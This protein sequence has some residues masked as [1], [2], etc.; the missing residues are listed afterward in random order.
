MVELRETLQITCLL[1][2]EP[3]ALPAGLRHGLTLEEQI[4]RRFGAVALL[5]IGQSGRANAVVEN[6]EPTLRYRNDMVRPIDRDVAIR[7][8]VED[9]ELVADTD[10]GSAVQDEQTSFLRV[11]EIARSCHRESLRCDRRA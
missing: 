1:A 10:A 2:G 3:F 5:A 8:A 4:F 9:P 6:G 7:P 11:S